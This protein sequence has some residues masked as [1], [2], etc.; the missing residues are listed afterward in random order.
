MYGL[1]GFLIVLGVLAYL[2]TGELPGFE[3]KNTVL[4]IALVVIGLLMM[5]FE[6]FRSRPRNL[7]TTRQTMTDDGTGRPVVHEENTE[8]RND[9][10]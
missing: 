9:G 1:G 2:F 8:M 3:G 4:G 5:V 6:Y 7:K 10:L